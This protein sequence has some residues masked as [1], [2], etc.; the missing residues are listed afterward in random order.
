MRILEYEEYKDKKEECDRL[1]KEL[2]PWFNDIPVMDVLVPEATD[3]VKAK[4]ER[5]VELAQEVAWY[6]DYHG[7][8]Y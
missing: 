7:L 1:Y 3:E 4:Y 5:M 8:K 2:E 6:E